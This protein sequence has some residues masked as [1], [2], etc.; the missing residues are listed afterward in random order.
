[1]KFMRLYSED[2]TLWMICGNNISA[3]S[4]KEGS[5]EITIHLNS[6]EKINSKFTVEDVLDFFKN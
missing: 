5:E 4:K 3:I 2:G 1:M 6:G